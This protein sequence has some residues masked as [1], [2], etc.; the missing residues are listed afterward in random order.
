MHQSERDYVQLVQCYADLES[1][2]HRIIAAN[3]TGSRLFAKYYRVGFYGKLFGD[4]NGKEYIYK[5]Y[6]GI[7]L[8]DISERLRVQYGQKFGVEKI[9]LLPNKPVDTT[10]LEEGRL[11]IQVVETTEY[12]EPHELEKRVTPFERAFG[13]SRF[14]FETPFVMPGKKMGDMEDQFKRR[15]IL[16]TAEPFPGMKKRQPIVSKEEIV[17]TPIETSID[18]IRSRV[19]A[20]QHEAT[21]PFPNTKTLQIVLQGSVLLQV[22]AGPLEICRIF[23]GDNTSKYPA[24]HV[25]TL[26]LLMRQF[27]DA[28]GA[29]LATNNRLIKAEQLPFQEKLQE[30]YAD[31]Q[32]KIGAYLERV[33]GS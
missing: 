13:I 6:A 27:L 30:G 26:R 17:L 22:N 23:L 1:L 29:A 18:L 4:G 20:L 21:S 2:C 32:Q 19:Q 11:F 28:S 8:A 15:T 10:T 5:E 24:E 33:E 12:L 14:F 16:T 31:A 25:A 7:R 3:E 9:S